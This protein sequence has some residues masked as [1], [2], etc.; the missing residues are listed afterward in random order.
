[1][2]LL[3]FVSR[4]EDSILTQ[5]SVSVPGPDGSVP[6]PLISLSQPHT[7]QTPPGCNPDN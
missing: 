3:H 1:M 5:V 4:G 7:T 6:G 2:Y